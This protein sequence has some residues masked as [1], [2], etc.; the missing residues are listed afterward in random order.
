VLRVVVRDTPERLA[1]LELAEEDLRLAGAI[2]T[3]ETVVADQLS[4][5]VEL[6]EEAG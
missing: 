1:A 5:E 6:A 4:V 2:E 3:I